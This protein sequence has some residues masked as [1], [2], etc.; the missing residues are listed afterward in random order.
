MKVKDLIEELQDYDP[1]DEVL[2]SSYRHGYSIS[3]VCS[4]D[5]SDDEDNK[6]CAVF[7]VEGYQKY[8]YQG[9]RD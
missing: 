5:V 2:I 4:S 3:E 6:T 9:V 7:I 1:D 8:P